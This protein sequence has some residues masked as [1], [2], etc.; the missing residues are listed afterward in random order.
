MNSPTV[1]STT[2]PARRSIVGRLIAK[3]LYLYRGYIAGAVVAGVGSLVLSHLLGGDAG[4]AGSGAPDLGILMFLTTVIAFGVSL[5]MIVLKEHQSKAQLFVLSLPVSPAQY[6]M[7]KV[8]AALVAFL[9]PWTV[10]TAG[11]AVAT[12]A[13]AAP[14]G[15]LPFFVAMMTF[16][17]GNFCLLMAIT[18]ITQSEAATIAAILVTNISV[19]IYLFQ[20]G[21]LPG[22]GEHRDGDVAVW[23]PAI[24]TVLAIE[25][26]VIL[27]ALALAIYL[28]SRR[29]DS[30]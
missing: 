25:V 3:D 22:I 14:D 28:P 27:A 7:A 18:V 11:V 6:S 24:L 19:T 1:S 8:A 12:L 4:N 26:A 13:T 23:S 10:L 29:K 15:P 9:V 17:L 30:V 2:S 21:R 5:P 16:F 20:V